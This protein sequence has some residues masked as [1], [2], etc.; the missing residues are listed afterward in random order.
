[1]G[2][3][4]NSKYNFFSKLRLKDDIFFNEYFE[5]IKNKESI[6][7]DIFNIKDSINCGILIK[8]GQFHI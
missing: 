4:K 3:L 5:N 6:M 7:Q 2:I 1:M 8:S